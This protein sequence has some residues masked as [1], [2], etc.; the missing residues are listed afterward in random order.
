VLQQ[1]Y[2]GKLFQTSI[3]P[4]AKKFNL[5]LVEAWGLN[6][7]KMCLLVEVDGDT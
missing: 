7:L 6:I 5:A 2:S 4:I 1:Y 3:V